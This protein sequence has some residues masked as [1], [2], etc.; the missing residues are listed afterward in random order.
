MAI[1]HRDAGA[2]APDP[3]AEELV[4]LPHQGGVGGLALPTGAGL[5][6][7]GHA[8]DHAA[9]PFDTRFLAIHSGSGNVRFPL[10]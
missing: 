4:R 7:R 9:S 1:P 6:R 8:G 2:R 5:A 3:Q 10:R